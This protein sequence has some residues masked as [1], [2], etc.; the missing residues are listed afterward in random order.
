MIFTQILLKFCDIKILWCV[1]YYIIEQF[2]C[3]DVN[4]VEKWVYPFQR[5]KEKVIW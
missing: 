1:V 3:T 2:T 4:E 5:A